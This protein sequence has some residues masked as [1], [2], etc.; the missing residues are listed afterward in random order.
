MANDR[1]YDSR[2]QPNL[3]RQER[4]ESKFGYE[5]ANPQPNTHDI[6]MEEA[7]KRLSNG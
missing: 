1:S 6:E 5:M 4:M 3:E 2:R 7:D